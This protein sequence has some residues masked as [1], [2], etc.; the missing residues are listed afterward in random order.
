MSSHCNEFTRC[1]LFNDKH[2]LNTIYFYENVITIHETDLFV[3][4]IFIEI[5]K[6][7]NCDFF[8]SI[9]LYLF[10]QFRNVLHLTI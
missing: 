1:H 8:L 2:N 4:F 3:L 6:F 5:L 10:Q 9:N 7:A